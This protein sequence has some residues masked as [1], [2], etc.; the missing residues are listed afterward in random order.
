[1]RGGALVAAA[2]AV[3]A[4]CGWG[5]AQ[6]WDT[7]VPGDLRLDVAAAEREFDPAA[8]EEAASF[9]AVVRWLFIG[10]QVVLVAVLA[11]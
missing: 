5:G 7:V 2:L 4:A 8:A 9:E 10:S 11:L 3:V 1:M 6:L